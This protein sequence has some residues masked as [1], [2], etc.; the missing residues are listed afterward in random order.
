MEREQ[1]ANTHVETQIDKGA[2]A[3]I[4][5]ILPPGQMPVERFYGVLPNIISELC[6]NG[7]WAEALSVEVVTDPDGKEA[8]GVPIWLAADPLVAP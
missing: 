7:F 1:P 8:L 2:S 3:T 6:R 5:L 4:W